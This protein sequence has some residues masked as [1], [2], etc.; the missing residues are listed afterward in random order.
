MSYPTLKPFQEE[1]IRQLSESFIKLW[2]TKNYKLPLIFK[3][4]TGAGKTLMMADFL[5]CLDMNYQFQEGI[6]KAY[7]WISFSED[8]YRQSKKKFYDYFNEGTDMHLKD[9]GNLNEEKLLENNIFFINWQKI[10]GT[11]KD[12]RLLR[13]DTENTNGEG[14]FDEYIKETHKD[15]RDLVLIIDEAHTQT[16]TDLADEVINLINPRI[17]IK[18]TATPKYLPN[19]SDVNQ[20]KAGFVEVFEKDVIDSGLIKEKIIIQ[21]EEEIRSIKEQDLDEDQMMLELACR[22]REELKQYYEKEDVKIN[23]L[24]LIQLPSDENETQD[25]TGNKKDIVLSYLKGN[26][27]IP[28]EKIAIWLSQEKANLENI[29]WNQSGVD[30]ML[31]KVAPATGWDCPRADILVMFREIKNPAFHTQILGRIKR[32][33]EGK[34][35]K[36]AELNNAYVYTNYN[37]SH[38]EALPETT[39]NKPLVHFTSLKDGIEPIQLKSTVHHK[40][41]YNTLV[42]IY[43]WEKCLHNQLHRSFGTEGISSDDLL[44][45]RT[46]KQKENYKKLNDKIN[47]EN[48]EVK[49][50]IVINAEIESFD[51]FI[52]QLKKEA[53]EA[54]YNLSE[55]DIQKLY[56]LLCFRELKN[57]EN[58]KAK[59]NPSRSWSP[60]KEALNVYFGEIVGM[61]STKYYKILV[62]EFLN[63]D[64]ELKKAIHLALIEFRKIH[65]DKIQETEGK[66]KITISIPEKEKCFTNDFE[67]LS[68]QEIQP[69]FFNQDSSNI[70]PHKNVYQKFYLKKSYHGRDN[71]L[72]FIRFLETQDIDW[73]HKQD[74]SG[75]NQFA[76]EYKDGQGGKDRLFYPD[77]IIKKDEI[78]YIVDTK[79]GNTLNSQDTKYKAE[80]L[81]KWIKDNQIEGF[82]KIVGGIIK[83]EYPSWKINSKEEYNHSNNDD[84][85]NLT[86]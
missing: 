22:K 40:T 5:R 80:A 27:Q 78:L 21:K 10:K 39:P 19:I 51:N 9:L 52:P 34:H 38:L 1:A 16:D 37:K 4:P 71:E 42:G 66:E 15:D 84:W 41:D 28:E 58:E 23:P 68:G 54:N 64:S 65:D 29:E 85:Q 12:S 13:R 70:S 74:D 45:K 48:P 77:W 6:N 60:L 81:Q 82:N 69:N 31:F 14:L 76:V 83:F 36:K 62:N 59:Y 55:M 67:L 75:R 2:K 26:K 44:A 56:N 47:L 18:V 25:I 63:P 17:I 33:P 73:W 30:F 3:A 32:M 24:V 50:Q 43:K 61:D 46:Q 79:S 35:Y 49:N 7:L 20:K 8:S 57:Q 72:N 53:N 11:T 86:F